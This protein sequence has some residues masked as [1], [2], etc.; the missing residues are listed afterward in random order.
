MKPIATP[1]PTLDRV[2][3]VQLQSGTTF[4]V[5]ADVVLPRIDADRRNREPLARFLDVFGAPV[6]I[7]V[8]YIAVTWTSDASQRAAERASAP[9]LGVG[10]T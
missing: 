9:G 1:P 6:E 7:T 8:A 5:D 3:F 4:L 10:R 2:G